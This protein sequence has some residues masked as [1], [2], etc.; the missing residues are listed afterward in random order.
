MCFK[1]FDHNCASLD[2]LNRKN[3][4]GCYQ[5]YCLRIFKVRSMLHHDTMLLYVC[6][7]FGIFLLLFNQKKCFYHF[8]FF[9]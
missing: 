4:L 5:R 9:F 8:H 7:Y 6:T 1:L 2:K 3:I